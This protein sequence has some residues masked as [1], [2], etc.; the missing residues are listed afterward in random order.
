MSVQIKRRVNSI[1]NVRANN[2]IEIA[3]DVV[4]VAAK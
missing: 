3:Q 2:K 1:N 4:N